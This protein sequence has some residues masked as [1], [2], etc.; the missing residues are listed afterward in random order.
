M[1]F[2]HKLGAMLAA[3]S[4]LAACGGETSPSY[5][6]TEGD[7]AEGHSPATATTAAANAKVA[8]QLP[9]DDQEDFELARKGL[10]AS[11]SSLVAKNDAGEEVWN[12]GNYDFITGDAPAS[13]NPSL[14][15]QAKLNGIHGLF[16][17]T[18]G[19]Y[20]LRGFDL[21]NLTIIES[22]NGW[23]LVDPLTGPQTSKV[24]ID[25]AREHLGDKPIKAILFTHSHIDHFGGIEGVATPEQIRDQGIRIVA[26]LGFVEE[27]VSE[28]V[29]AGVAMQRRAGLMYGKNLARNERGHVDTGLGKE[30]PFGSTTSITKPTDIISKTGQ[31]LNIDGVEIEF[32]YTPASEAPAEFTFYLPKQKAFCG[33]EVVSRNLHNVYTLRGAK[34]RNALVWSNYIEEAR[35]QFGEADIYFA[36]HHWPLWG[37]DKIQDFLKKQRDIYKYIHDQTLRMANNGMTPLEIADA[38]TLP[39]S[40]ETN[41]STRG[42]YGTL[43]HNA[44]AVYN[45]YF[46]YYDGNP[47]NLNPLSPSDAGNKYVELAGGAVALIEKAQTA[48][49]NGE[50]RWAAQLLNHLVFAEPGNDAG[51]QLL[52]KS[53]D[54]LGYQAE[55]GPWRDVYLGA[56]Y[57]LRHGGPKTGVNMTDA[58]GML[59]AIPI[60]QF[61]DSMAAR[62]DGKKAEGKDI[63]VKFTFTDLGESHRLW[64][65][66][67]VLHHE[68]ADENTEADATIELTHEL[69]LKMVIGKAGIKDTLLSDDMNIDGS[70]LKLVGF[71]R[72]LDKPDGKFA[73]VTPD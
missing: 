16:K 53:Y 69:F 33:A 73:I 9:L 66:N 26:P 6:P 48:F 3:A 11:M 2:P 54:Q 21:A 55:S 62:V 45:W 36:S 23:I 38:I 58:I 29:M 43:R 1:N 20:Q 27:A 61:F 25:F 49:D 71:F 30:P 24:A 7:N 32:Q 10:I 60:H 22:D 42:Y 72:L 51:R 52:A 70:R 19:I 15:R 34:V 64:L 8:E 17:V 46:G 44:R 5:T 50:Y 59:R 4:L 12:Q 63:S 65:E 47:A 28:N 37:K 68:I 40:L 35:K 31:T 39:A 18:E 41:F 56:A 13:V 67:S 57:E 14:W